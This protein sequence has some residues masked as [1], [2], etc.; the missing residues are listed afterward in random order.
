M[1][2]EM[3]RSRGAGSARLLCNVL[4][5][6]DT[7]NA[8]GLLSSQAMETSMTPRLVNQSRPVFAELAARP[9]RAL[10]F[11]RLLMSLS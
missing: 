10:G 3:T 1:D 11:H 4:S 9:N 7:R 5:G 6:A 2:R 8:D